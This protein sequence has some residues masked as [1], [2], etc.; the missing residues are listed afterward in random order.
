[1]RQEW[2]AEALCR[3][4]GPEP[5]FPENDGEA[6]RVKKFCGPCPV[7]RECLR[8]AL[9]RDER[10]IWGGTTRAER[11]RVQERLGMAP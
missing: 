5:F 4:I 11:R 3:E 8:F 6:R 10:G 9:K 7:R 1:M 2:M